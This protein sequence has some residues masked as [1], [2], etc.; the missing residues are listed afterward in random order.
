MFFGRVSRVITSAAV[1]AAIFA[2]MPVEAAHAERLLCQVHTPNKKGKNR[3]N[4]LSIVVGS[5]CPSGSRRIGPIL[6]R[7]DVAPLVTASLA[8]G[9]QGP[10][11]DTGATG[12]QGEVGP[13]GIAG[14][15]G[16]RGE[17][18]PQGAQGVAGPVGATGAIGPVGPSGPQGAQGIQGIA[19]PV[20]PVGP[21]G[22]T[23]RAG[24]DFVLNRQ[25]LA[26]ENTQ[27][28]GNICQLID[29]RSQCNSDLG[30]RIRMNVFN[31]GNVRTEDKLVIFTPSSTYFGARKVSNRSVD[32][33]EQNYQVGTGTT[34]KV[35]AY[36]G[37][38][39]PSYAV[40]LKNSGRSSGVAGDYGACPVGYNPQVPLRD[41][42]G[43]I[44]LNNQGQ[45]ILVSVPETPGLNNS[46]YRDPFLTNLTVPPGTKVVISVTAE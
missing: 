18:G 31:G 27:T 20:G 42:N 11:G 15:Q 21:R 29:L 32:R 25:T 17:V 39:F 5:N 30:C 4:Q 14:A 33:D 40:A 12:P 1:L 10:K 38:N 6:G 35:W 13:R 22:E 46:G 37:P 43:N 23:G 7:E 19:G 26:V 28:T 16:P 44:V 2:V 34:A 41:E 36:F 8:T 45:Q 9:P 24:Q 3:L